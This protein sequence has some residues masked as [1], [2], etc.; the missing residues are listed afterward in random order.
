L[1]KWCVFVLVTGRRARLDLETERFFANADEPG[2]SYGDKLA[3]YAG[4]TD[5]YFESERYHAVSAPSPGHLAAL[6]QD[7]VAGPRSEPPQRLRPVGPATGDRLGRGYL[8]GGAG[9]AGE[10]A[11]LD[12]AEQAVG[13]GR[14]HAPSRAA[15]RGPA[16]AAGGAR[17]RPLAP[18]RG[19]ASRAAR[20]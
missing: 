14:V 11:L 5:A 17:A 3:A 7:W 12:D 15:P 1:V 13:M 19:P 10:A 4:L 16:A 6:D 18:H 20:P 2:A 8:P 9:P